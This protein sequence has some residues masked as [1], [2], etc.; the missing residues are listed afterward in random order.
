VAVVAVVV[1]AP[2]A[3]A[4]II[5]L[6]HYARGKRKTSKYEEGQGAAKQRR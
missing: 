1:I 6:V 4:T 2:V 5:V 3:T